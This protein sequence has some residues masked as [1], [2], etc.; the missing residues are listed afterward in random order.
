M[1]SKNEGEII[2]QEGDIVITKEELNLEILKK[3]YSNRF[4]K[5]GERDRLVKYIR[6][7]LINS[8]I[9]QQLKETCRQRIEEKGGIQNVTNEE[10]ISLI[11]PLAKKTIDEDLKKEVS[12]KIKNFL[13]HI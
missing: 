2:F 8:G 1:T 10:L 6:A 5:S 13:S 7:K 9:R 3:E 11:S 4:R 12:V